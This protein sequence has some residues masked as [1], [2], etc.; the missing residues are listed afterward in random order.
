MRNL[1]VLLVFTSA[2]AA[3]QYDKL[4]KDVKELVKVS[5]PRW[6]SCT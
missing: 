2:C 5:A 6:R 3:Q 1:L 4:A